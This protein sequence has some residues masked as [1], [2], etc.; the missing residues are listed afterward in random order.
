MILER[1]LEI[2]NANM[3]KLVAYMGYLG[4]GYW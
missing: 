2:G 4:D 3:I 1:G